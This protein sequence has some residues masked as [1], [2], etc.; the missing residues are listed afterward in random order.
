MNRPRLRTAAILLPLL[1]GVAACEGADERYL[2]S[3]DRT[4][5]VEGS[6]YLDLNRDGIPSGGE[7]ALPG[8]NIRLVMSGSQDTVAVATS[9]QDGSFVALDISGGSYDVVAGGAILG[10]SLVLTGVSPERVQVSPN[11]VAEVAV[12]FSFPLY[13]IPVAAQ[14]ATG[15]RLYVEGVVLNTR[16][17]LPNDAVHVWDGERAMRT[18]GVASFTHSVGDSVR[19]L[20]R[21]Q[22]ADG[23]TI[24]TGGQGFRIAELLPLDPIALTTQQA[25]TAS[26]GGP[27]GA[28]DGALVRVEEALVSEV[29]AVQGG[30]VATASDGSPSVGIRIPT[31]HLN[32]A[33]IPTLQPGAALSVTGILIPA[34]GTGLWELHTRSGN[35]ITV[36]AQGGVLGRTF[37]DQ[38]GNG[39][40][41]AGDSPL[42]GVRLRLYRS[43]DLQTPV[44]VV[45]SDADGR[46]QISPLDV[47]QYTLEADE[48]TIPDSL[49][50]RNV[51]PGTFNVPTGGTVEVA[52]AI[53]H[54]QVTSAQAR[55]LPV[56]ETVF[57]QGIALN[58]LTALGDNS[59]HL[60][61]DGGAL[62]TLEVSGTVR[63]GDRVRL[64][65]RTDEVAGQRVLRDVV[66]FL[67][68]EGG[69]PG[70][71]ILD[72]VGQ[73]RTALGGARDAD[74]VRVRDVAVI[75]ATGN[76]ERWIVTVNDGTGTGT[77]DL[78]VR[79]ATVGYS[80]QQAQDRFQVGRRLDVNGL[81]IPEEGAG[82]WRIHPRTS[83]DLTFLDP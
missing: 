40:F 5:T 55:E 14:Q 51:S 2:L 37:Y 62:R 23:R 13:S 17:S 8:V 16:G 22:Q 61:D 4:G 9:D 10:D 52:V 78:Y 71:V 29:R 6:T 1:L 77:V 80:N 48:S 63:A 75:A 34:E 70:P 21:V 44:R 15:T 83:G 11:S 56:G 19:I 73:A 49:V 65:G 32:Q 24:L 12:G 64:R 3:L 46:F 50:V 81:L 60:R 45:D 79:L 18:E 67:Q 7:V 30:V 27:I 31:A 47:N 36:E 33:G 68:S 42:A 58:A 59:V 39:S 72:N 53:S 57:L 54:P 25:R 74:A 69:V 35:D 26:S 38:N 82:V 66:P 43:N 28:L 76:S 41:D 20:G